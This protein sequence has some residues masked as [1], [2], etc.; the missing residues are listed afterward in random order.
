[1]NWENF[2]KITNTLP[3]IDTKLLSAGSPD[4][5]SLEVQIARWAKS[6][7]LIQLRRGLYLLAESYRKNNPYE[8]FVASVLVNPSYISL[9]KALEYHNLIPEAVPTFTS[10]TT[11]RPGTFRTTIGVFEYQHIKR[12]LFWGYNSTTV[13]HQTAF[14]ASPEKALLDFLYFR[15][16]KITPPYLEELRLQNTD[17]VD[18]KKLMQ[19]ARKFEK[20][21]M[22]KAAALLRKHIESL[23]D[24]KKMP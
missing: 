15:N 1:M 20:T 6:G 24:G 16:Q 9:E 8:P 7:K 21:F 4:S 23:T 18:G 10:V 22:V 2:L 5:K 19:C 14:I 11:K 17:V 3:L 13:N 12:S